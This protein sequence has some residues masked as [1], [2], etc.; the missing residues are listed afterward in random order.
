MAGAAGQLWSFTRPGPS[1]QQ[2]A[3]SHTWG[4]WQRGPERSLPSE[5]EVSWREPW[6]CR[7]TAHHGRTCLLASAR[8]RPSALLF[9][10][11]GTPQ[12]APAA[13]RVV[14]GRA[15]SGFPAPRGLVHRRPHDQQRSGRQPHGPD[16][17][18]FLICKQLYGL[19]KQRECGEQRGCDGG[20]GG[21][22]GGRL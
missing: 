3:G 22:A 16:T 18:T 17:G 6:A 2:P 8:G 4:P 12:T 14:G 10:E 15:A 21:H 11:N 13:R 20:R 7:W 19:E 1:G 9:F 5:G